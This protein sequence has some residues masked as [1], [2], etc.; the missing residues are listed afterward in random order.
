MFW[1]KCQALDNTT[2]P[3][4]DRD[5][6]V[7]ALQPVSAAIANC[8]ATQTTELSV[9]TTMTIP[10]KMYTKTASIEWDGA[11]LKGR[12]K[13]R[14]DR[15]GFFPLNSPIIPFSCATCVAVEQ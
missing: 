15:V 11:L 2:Y 1:G 5:A 3:T 7:K 14:F 10:I 9:R 4:I 13:I 8:D 12:I 6:V